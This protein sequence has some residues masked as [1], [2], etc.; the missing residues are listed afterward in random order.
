MRHLTLAAE[1]TQSALRDDYLGPMMPEEIGLPWELWTKLAIGTTDIA[2]SSRSAWKNDL[3]Q[4]P[5]N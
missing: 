2:P 4:Q 3:S 1:Y 5:P